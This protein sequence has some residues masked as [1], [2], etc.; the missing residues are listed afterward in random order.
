MKLKFLIYGAGVI[1]SL[2]A[3]KLSGAGYE[4]TVLARG[5]RY[6][7]LERNGVV[8]QDAYSGQREVQ[9]VRTISSLEAGDIYDY[10]LVVVQKTQ[11]TEILPILARNQS[12]NIVFFVNNCL[13]YDEWAEAVGA[14][15]LMLI[16]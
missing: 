11:V 9:R 3:G 12:P 7:E 1:G 4:V 2:F 15:R 16:C 6:E 14:Q 5:K 10:L 8:L 13:G